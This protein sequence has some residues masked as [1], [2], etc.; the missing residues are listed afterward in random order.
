[1][2]VRDF[3]LGAWL[4][5]KG[6]NHRFE[7]GKLIFDISKKEFFKQKSDYEKS[8]FKRY[9]DTVKSLIASAK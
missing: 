9:H 1:M 2:T 6:F 3:Y 8:S 5:D 7:Q 4:I